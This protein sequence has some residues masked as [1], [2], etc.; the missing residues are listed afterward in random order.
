MIAAMPAKPNES[1]TL[2]QVAQQ[3]G[4]HLSTASRAL[5]PERR[6]LISRDI[7]AR[8]EAAAR[9]VGWRPNRAAAS[10]RRGRSKAIGVLIPD[11]A[12]LVTAQIMQGI[13][14]AIVSRGFF[15]LVVSTRATPAKA[16]V[17]R[18]LWQRVE[19]V[20]DASTD[21]E[22]SRAL[23][24]AGVPTVLTSRADPEG[25]FSSVNSDRECAANLAIDH[26]H[27]LGHR[28]I[29]V[30]ASPQDAQVSIDRLNYCLAALA[31]HGLQPDAV[32]VADA[33]SRDAGL[34]AFE[35]LLAQRSPRGPYR[36]TA[37]CAA[38]DLLALGAYEAA[39]KTGLSIPHD[40]SVVGQNDMLMAD[41]VS[42]PLTTV[43][44][45]HYDMGRQAGDL[46]IEEIEAR[47]SGDGSR[48]PPRVIVF[49][50]EFVVREST[51]A[52]AA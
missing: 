41:L 32:A 21:S 29:A 22:M 42:P 36:F 37:V 4:V 31:R 5:D 23:A 16:V 39:R 35:P 8:V 46:L 1:A 30:L 40:F 19:G 47:M 10:L 49:R 50:P 52:P 33:S 25:Q 2:R 14:A 45:Q 6:H 7:V 20:V 24:K 27:A 18:L 17:D 11:M 34:R 9:S 51:A 15:P 28:A 26:L 3:A 48:R 43:R 13:E 12:N 38:N 44:L